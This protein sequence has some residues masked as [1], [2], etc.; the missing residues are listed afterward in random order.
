MTTLFH[1]PE[2]KGMAAY[3]GEIEVDSKFITLYQAK[4]RLYIVCIEGK[5][6][7]LFVTSQKAVN[8]FLKTL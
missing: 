1:E 6:K 3:L 2:F 7:P 4:K 8:E 5:E